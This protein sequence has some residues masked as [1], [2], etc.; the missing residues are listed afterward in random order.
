MIA[1]CSEV[2][3]GAVEPIPC[4]EMEGAEPDSGALTGMLTV[5]S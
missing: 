2:R 3:S 1:A 4:G 5:L